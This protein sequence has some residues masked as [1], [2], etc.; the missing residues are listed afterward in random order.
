MKVWVAIEQMC[1]E[2]HYVVLPIL[3]VFSTMEAASE[4]ARYHP[5]VYVYQRT[6]E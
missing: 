5:Q 4:F 1:G 6:L 3:R 2:Q